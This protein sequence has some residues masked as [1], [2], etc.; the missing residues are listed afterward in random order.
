[1]DEHARRGVV[2]RLPPQ[3]HDAVAA[4]AAATWRTFKHELVYL[5][6]Q[7]AILATADQDSRE[8]Q[9]ARERL[10]VEGMLL[11]QAQEGHTTGE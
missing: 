10:D 3:T 7:A 4:L 8:Y 6:E 1:M 5:L 11:R 9:H 2:L